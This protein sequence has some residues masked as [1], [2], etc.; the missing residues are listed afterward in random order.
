[1]AQTNYTSWKA[2]LDSKI[3]ENAQG[4]V[5]ATS[6]NQ[7]LTD[8][9]ESVIWSIAQQGYD[10]VSTSPTIITFPLV[11]SSANY[12]IQITPIDAQGDPVDVA[13]T[14]ITTSSMTLTGAV[15]CNVYW[16]ITL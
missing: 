1:M 12:N 7:L 3:Y 14:N 6:V 11:M 15:S 4:L 9:G 13:I 16:R 2:D 5:T 10:V 8:L